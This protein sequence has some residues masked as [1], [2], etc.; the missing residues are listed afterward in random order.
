M[1]EFLRPLAGCVANISVSESNESALLGFP[2]WQINRATLQIVSALFGQGVSVVFGHD[3]RDD[4]IMEAVFGFARQT[5]MPIAGIDYQPILFN[6]LP[7]PD[8]PRLDFKELQQL[9]TTLRVESAGLP[10]ELRPFERRGLESGPDSPLYRYLR[11]RALTFLRIKLGRLSHV[12]LCI[13]G[14]RSGSAGRYPGIVEEALLAVRSRMPLY[15][16]GLLGGATKQVIDAIEG[17]SMPDDFCDAIRVIELYKK[18]PVQETNTGNAEDRII[19]REEIWDEFQSVGRE[20]IAKA[21][22]LTVEENDELL[23]TQ[24]I[25]RVIELVLIGLSRLR[26]YERR[27]QFDEK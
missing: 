2:P 1:S 16:M 13:G 20:G 8:T 21:N 4:G 11:A 27:H 26:P 19:K 22:R 23:H 9:S 15:L 10:E 17:K 6:L 14:R 3:W 24:T 25:D 7:W 5:Q 18:P 12:R